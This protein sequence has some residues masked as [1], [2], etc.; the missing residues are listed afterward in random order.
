V[1]VHRVTWSGAGQDPQVVGIV[2]A[3][4]AAT[5]ISVTLIKSRNRTLRV[6]M[7]RALV[8]SRIHR[9]L[10]YGPS[11][12]GRLL[13]RDHSSVIAMFRKVDQLVRQ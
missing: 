7:A 9:E 13:N 6:A 12:I 1:R 3:V 8:A 10:N 2:A 11:E 4:V 5:G